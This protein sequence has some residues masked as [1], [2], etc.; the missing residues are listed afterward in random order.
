MCTTLLCG[1]LIR[2]NKILQAKFHL[3]FLNKLA[4]KRKSYD[5]YGD[6][7]KFLSYCKFLLKNELISTCSNEYCQT[8]LLKQ[9]SIFYANH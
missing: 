5:F 3:A 2:E 8:G 7:A 4:P 9:E 6:E 1:N